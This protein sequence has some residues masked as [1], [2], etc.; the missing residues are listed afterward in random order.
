MFAH[1]GSRYA[2]GEPA[3]FDRERA[4][5]PAGFIAFVKATQPEVWQALEKLHGPA[6]EAVIPDDLTTRPNPAFPSR[7]QE[8][9]PNLVPSAS[10]CPVFML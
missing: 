5:F 1:P 8:L 6:T 10:L 7:N 3:A 2:K 4:I 9:C